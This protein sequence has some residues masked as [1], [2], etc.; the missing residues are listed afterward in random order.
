ME[1]LDN[2]ASEMNILTKY[3]YVSRLANLTKSVVQSSG[4]LTVDSKANFSTGL[5]E[6]A[7][8]KAAKDE[9]KA[10]KKRQ[11]MLACQPGANK[12]KKAPVKSKEVFVN[13]T[14]VGEKKDMT[15]PI[16]DSY[17]PTAVEA[18]WDAWWA[19]KKFFE[20]DLKQALNK[21][22]D[23]RFIMLLPPP[24]VT[25]SLHL[26]HTL[27]GAIEDSITRW[28][29]MKGFVSLWVPGTDHAGIATQSVVEKKIL[30]ET[31]KYRSDFT[32]EEFL[33]KVWEWKNEYGNRIF[34]QF[35]RL[36]VSFDL[37]RN[38]FTMDDQRSESVKHAFIDLFDR[39]ILYRSERMVH[40]CCALKTAIS[41]VEL[42]EIELNGPTML[43]V[44]MHKDKVEFGVLHDFAYK[45]KDDPTKEI[46]VSTTRIETMLGDVAVAVHSQDPRYKDL[47]GKELVHPFIPNRHIKIVT[48]D[49]LVNM[50]FGTGAVKITPAHD[51]N[52][53]ACGQ[54]NTLPIINIFTEDGI[55]NQNGGQFEVIYYLKSGPEKI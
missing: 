6:K 8:E 33:K 28:R 1:N 46:I 17:D 50:E 36:G 15:A 48:D 11:M 13:K 9:A 42:D 43:A 34:E 5:D 29:R 32:R 16:A 55:V 49:I 54:R 45:V 24:N 25:G 7:R 21:P 35:R 3:K 2:Q 30:K 4:I 44:P 19:K 37:S 39:G 27:M 12:A 38:F 51:P 47:V 31:G 40:W 14:P 20:V 52:D 53:F 22:K 10:E 18:A 23:Q 26:G 41:D